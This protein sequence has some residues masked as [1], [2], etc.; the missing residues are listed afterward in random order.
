A[1]L[2]MLGGA[3]LPRR[4]PKSVFAAGTAAIAIGALVLTFVLWHQVQDD[5]AYALLGGAIVLD[6]PALFIT[7]VILSAILLTALFL[8]DYLEREGM[9]GAEI[10]ALLITSALGG[11]VMAW[12]SDLI[13]LFL[14]LE[15]LSMALYILAASH[16][17][18]IQSQE[19]GIK[20][21]ILGG[22]SSAFF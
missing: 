6:G 19:S 5:G 9:G 7:V 21:F 14:G 10:Y 12:A 17:R 11:I 1:V 3:L 15:V 20:Y 13:V 4:V 22:F 2:L 16:L 8:E 18:R